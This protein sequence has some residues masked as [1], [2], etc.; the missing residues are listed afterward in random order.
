[1]SSDGN[2]FLLP[3]Q[4]GNSGCVTPICV[5]IDRDAAVWIC[6]T[7]H[8]KGISGTPLFSQTK[9]HV[10]GVKAVNRDL[11]HIIK[12]SRKEHQSPRVQ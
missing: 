10:Y 9:M 2:S 4:C 7:L 12:I 5:C 8:D 1:M 11:A 3:M 6:H